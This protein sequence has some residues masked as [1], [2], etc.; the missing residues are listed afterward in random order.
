MKRNL[1]FALLSDLFVHCADC[2][3]T[4]GVP[5]SYNII[6]FVLLYFLLLRNLFVLFLVISCEKLA[7]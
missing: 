5:F 2:S 3:G 1:I 6:D 7:R 4:F